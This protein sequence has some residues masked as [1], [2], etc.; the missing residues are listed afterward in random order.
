LA[1]APGRGTITTAQLP[2]RTISGRPTGWTGGYALP[3]YLEHEPSGRGAIGTEWLQRKY[4][5]QLVPGSLGS[6]GHDYGPDAPLALTLPQEVYAFDGYTASGDAPATVAPGSARDPYR[7][8]G[9]RVSELI[10]GTINEVPAEFR[11]IALSSLLNELQPGLF[12][13]VTGKAKTYKA[14]GMDEKAA[15]KAAIAASVSEKVVKQILD[16][17]KGKMPVAKSLMGLGMYDGAYEQAL[18][19]LGWSVGGAFKSIGSGV[20]K[21]ATTVGGGVKKAATTV[22][23][24]GKKALKKI[25]KLHCTV[26]KSPISDVVAGGVA[27]F[28]GV[29]PQV[30][31]AGHKAVTG[32]VCPAGTQPMPEEALTTPGGL[33]VEDKIMGVPKNLLL[34]IGIGAAG[35]LLFVMMK[36]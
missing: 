34:P 28:Y 21:A 18:V 19:G 2:R 36:K 16:M 11:Q 1:E 33:L 35:L 27:A 6:L 15:V 25:Y 10:M 9:Q 14:K 29:P 31:I 13:T 24:W 22:Y 23:K 17:G 30:G 4:T 7:Q 8:Y 32:V 3:S 5:D 12:D 20:K 26:M